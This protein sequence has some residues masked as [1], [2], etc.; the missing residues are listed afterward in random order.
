MKMAALRTETDWLYLW[1]LVV[2]PLCVQGFPIARPPLRFWTFG[3][4]DSSSADWF[5]DK[6]RMLPNLLS[7]RAIQ[8]PIRPR[9]RLPQPGH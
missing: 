4:L 1:N 9:T 5:P 7:P 8:L 3:H 6:Q 2:L